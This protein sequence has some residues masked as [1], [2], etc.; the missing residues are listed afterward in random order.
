MKQ[1][2]SISFKFTAYQSLANEICVE[3]HKRGFICFWVG[4]AVRDLLLKQKFGD[5]D[6]ATSANPEEIKKVLKDG[7]FKLYTLGEKFGTIGAVTKEGNIE[8][9]TFRKESGYSDQRHPDKIIFS[10][11]VKED[12]TRRDFTINALYFNPV[13]N[14]ILDFHNG[15]KDLKKGIIRFVGEPEERIKEDPLRLLRAVRFGTNLGFKLAKKDLKAI[16]KY[17][18][19]IKNISSQR[20]KKELDKIFLERYFVEG[21]ML[22]EKT[23]L[24]KTLFPEVDNLKKVDQSNDYHAE[25]NVYNHVLDALREAQKNLKVYNLTLRYAI[26]FH[27]IGKAFTA[28]TGERKGRVH[29]SFHGHAQKSSELFL[30]ISKRLIF[31]KQQRKEIEWLLKHHMDMLNLSEVTEKTLV[32]WAKNDLIEDLIRLRIAD[33]LGGTMTDAKGKVIPKDISKLK[34]M[35][36]KWKKLNLLY[37]TNLIT[38]EDVMRSLKIKPSKEVG[39]VL[40]KV[41]REQILGRIKNR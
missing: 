30:N 4:G 31:P 2:L 17:A 25:G 10:K 24:L 16:I 21:I 23:E 36:S 33:S 1:S 13:D 26:F 5:V 22:L 9:T 20:I 27:D 40:E 35:I 18:S 3:F 19:E 14:Q 7:G 11:E 41:K 37:K 6:L 12:S 8:I 32:K 28:K 39:Y 29:I 34:E 15:L 38:G